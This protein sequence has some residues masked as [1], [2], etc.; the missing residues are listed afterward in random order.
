MST[1]GWMD[2]EDMVHIYNG[3]LLS[4]KKEQNNAICSDM[5]GP[6]DCHTEW[7]K[8][9]RERQILYITY[10]WNLKKWYMWTYVQNRNRVT[11]VEKKLMVTKGDRG[12]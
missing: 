12:G 7:I 4:H 9:D 10:M 8:S 11:Y 3:L 6:R 2:K 5:D 1:D